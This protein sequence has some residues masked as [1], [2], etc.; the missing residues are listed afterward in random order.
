MTIRVD[1]E[2]DYLALQKRLH[3][4]PQ[5]IH[6]KAIRGALRKSMVHLRPK[7][8]AATPVRTGAHR[9][10]LHV[11]VKVTGTKTAWGRVTYTKRQKAE[12]RWWAYGS[13]G[14][15]RHPNRRQPPRGDYMREIMARERNTIHDIFRDE[16]A[17]ALHAA[18]VGSG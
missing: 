13:G 5:K 9:K 2:A 3:E 4:L 15:A 10:G 12:M 1:V 6:N 17:K 18:E 7:V 16:L 14:S 8:R 11:S